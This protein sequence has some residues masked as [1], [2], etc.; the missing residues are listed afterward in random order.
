MRASTADKPQ[1]AGST[2]RRPR[3]SHPLYAPGNAKTS[4]TAAV[5]IQVKRPT[6]SG[7]GDGQRESR[8]AS[9]TSRLGQP[10]ART[11]SGGHAAFIQSQRSARRDHD[12]RIFA[13]GSIGTD[14]AP[15]GLNAPPTTP[16]RRQ[17]DHERWHLHRPRAHLHGADELRPLAG[18]EVRIGAAQRSKQHRSKPEPREPQA[19]G[20]KATAVTPVRERA[21]GMGRDKD[22]EERGTT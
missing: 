4:S 13:R 9:S 22:K 17:P 18:G 2:L 1:N 3:L 11:R 14:A 10:H 20:A 7:P 15:V 5:A 19:P 12:L 16:S 8:N 6:G 21:M